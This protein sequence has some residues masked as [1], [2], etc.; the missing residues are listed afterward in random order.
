MEWRQFSPMCDNLSLIMKHWMKHLSSLSSLFIKF[1]QLLNKKMSRLFSDDTSKE[2]YFGRYF[3]ITLRENR[4]G[5]QAAKEKAKGCW[6]MLII[7]QTYYSSLSKFN[8]TYLTMILK[9]EHSKVKWTI[10][11]S[12]ILTGFSWHSREEESPCLVF[13]FVLI[14]CRIL[15]KNLPLRPTWCRLM[16]LKVT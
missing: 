8:W 13:Q 1:N 11:R 16:S 4:Q 3:Q 9:R 2:K 5:Q 10:N 12:S 7:S 6:K 15:N 14:V